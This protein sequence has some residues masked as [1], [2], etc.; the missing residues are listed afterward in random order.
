MFLFIIYLIIKLL[1]NMVDKY[2]RKKR[3][4]V[5]H[6]SLS[7]YVARKN[8]YGNVFIKILLMYK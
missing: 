7:E 6:I 3:N 2:L 4:R 8:I 1:L 5:T